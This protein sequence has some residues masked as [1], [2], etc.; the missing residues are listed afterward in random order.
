MLVFQLLLVLLA[1]VL[2]GY[3]VARNEITSRQ[4]AAI[5]VLVVVYLIGQLTNSSIQSILFP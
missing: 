5:I 1:V 4:S 2:L 3:D